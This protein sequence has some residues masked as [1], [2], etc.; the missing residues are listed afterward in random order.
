MK[1]GI[2]QRQAAAL[3][4]CGLVL[5]T[6]AGAGCVGGTAFREAAGPAVQQGITLI[7]DGLVEGLFAV[8]EPDPS[9]VDGAGGS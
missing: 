9:S 6:N 2:R 3:A 8:V 7:L 5:F 4:V 1:R